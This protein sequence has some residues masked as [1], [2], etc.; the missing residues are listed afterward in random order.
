[1]VSWFNYYEYAL[2]CV[3][4]IMFISAKADEVVTELGQY[5]ELRDA[6]DILVR[7]LDN[8]PLTMVQRLGIC[9]QKNIFVK[10]F[11]LSKNL[12]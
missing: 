2:C 7:Q 10:P 1:M 6:Q 4:G 9:Q 11:L 5:F 3:D 12:G 8:I